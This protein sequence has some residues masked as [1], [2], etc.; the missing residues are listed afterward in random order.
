[1]SGEQEHEIHGML[2]EMRQEK[3]IMTEHE[4]IQTQEYIYWDLWIA[5]KKT[6][7]PEMKIML[8][9]NTFKLGIAIKKRICFLLTVKCILIIKNYTL[10]IVLKINSDSAYLNLINVVYRW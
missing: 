9:E 1:M 8:Y 5:I 6:F 7:I 4:M 3:E 10:I 2:R